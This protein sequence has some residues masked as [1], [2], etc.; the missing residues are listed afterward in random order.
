VNSKQLFLSCF[1]VV[2]LIGCAADSTAPIVDPRLARGGSGGGSTCP[3]LPAGTSS[4]VIV[5]GSVTLSVNAT[6]DLQVVNQNGVTVPD[7]AVKWSSDQPLIAA[8]TNTGLVTAVAVGGPVRIR[9]S[10]SGKKPIVGTATVIVS[11]PPVSTVEVTPADNALL[12][13]GQVQLTAVAKDAGGAVLSGVA[14]T[15]SSNNAGV[16]SVNS[17]GL[18]SAISIG[19]ATITATADNV[20]GSVPVSVDAP[21]TGKLLVVKG[22]VFSE[23]QSHLLSLSGSRLAPSTGDEQYLYSG[24]FWGALAPDLSFTLQGNLPF[25]DKMQRRDA[26]SGWAPVIIFGTG[27]R[28]YGAHLS[29]DGSKVVWFRETFLNPSAR[30]IWIG[31]PNGTNAIQ[32]TAD[33]EQDNVPAISPNNQ[34][35]V[36]SRGG[37][38]RNLWIMNA[39]G[40]GKTQLT[41]SNS[42]D[43]PRFSPDG[44]RIVFTSNRSGTSALYIMNADGSNV[45]MLPGTEGLWTPGVAGEVAPLWSPD[46]QTIVFNGKPAAGI[47]GIFVVPSDGSLPPKRLRNNLTPETAYDWR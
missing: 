44:S 39:D 22:T 40:S 19:S 32:L 46:G 1:A 4:L 45:R 5:P 27:A 43:N 12:V 6:A 42:D 16:A 21:L 20:S 8:V 47:E 28:D 15:W 2:A 3:G 36:W 10:S 31:S 17:T 9:A 33:S 30:E 13:N 25:S 41:A 35:I 34:R 23:N 14:I 29:R 38:P 11:R 26:A 24:G 18:V 7:C 37:S